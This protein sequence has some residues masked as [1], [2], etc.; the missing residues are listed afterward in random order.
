[1]SKDGQESQE[2]RPQPGGSLQGLLQEARTAKALN[3]AS[4][5]KKSF[6]FDF[7]LL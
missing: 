4:T 2:G 1:L 7:L 6:L 5:F 3:R